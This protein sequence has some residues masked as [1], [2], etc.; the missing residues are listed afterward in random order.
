MPAA[1]VGVPGGYKRVLDE[2]PVFPDALCRTRPDLPWVPDDRG[3]ESGPLTRE[4][5]NLCCT[6][7]HVAP[8]A[9]YAIAHPYLVGIWGGLTTDQRHALADRPA[10]EPPAPPEHHEC[11]VCGRVFGRLHGLRMHH[12]HRHQGIPWL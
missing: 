2:L 1:G 11:R 7:T 8:C 9:A 12:A 10:A 3:R 4:A 6:C 5:L